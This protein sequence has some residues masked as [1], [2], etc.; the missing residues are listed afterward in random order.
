MC[1]TCSEHR[2]P[3]ESQEI[4]AA[5]SY[6]LFVADDVITE[7]SLLV[8][9]KI[10]NQLGVVIHPTILLRG[11]DLGFVKDAV[12]FCNARNIPL[13]NHF[14][15]YG[16]PPEFYLPAHQRILGHDGVYAKNLAYI[17]GASQDPL[18]IMEQAMYHVSPH[19]ILHSLEDEYHALG[20]LMGRAPEVG[21]VHLDCFKDPKFLYAWAEFT[22][23][24]P[25]MVF[26]YRRN[27]TKRNGNRIPRLK[28]NLHADDTI[29]EF[30]RDVRVTRED[31]VRMIKIKEQITPGQRKIREVVTHLDRYSKDRRN[32]H[33]LDANHVSQ[34][35]VFLDPKFWHED[36]PANNWLAVHA[37]QVRRLKKN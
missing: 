35:N 32:L 24:H 1:E 8:C 5:S 22:A 30:N 4:P 12:A 13:G 36:L 11:N 3:H 27:S 10:T 2:P 37:H 16:A 31:V 23:N 29:D 9:D 17:E 28:S 19:V 33:H 14:N 6:L 25:D 7:D 26:R 20:T 21:T 15:P 34:W 18:T